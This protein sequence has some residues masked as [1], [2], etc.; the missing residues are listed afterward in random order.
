M[1]KKESLFVYGT[2]A[3]SRLQNEL[4]GR[5][6]LGVADKLDGYALDSV[7]IR[8]TTYPAL[9]PNPTANVDGLVLLVTPHE[10]EILD[11]YETAAY[12]RVQVTLKSMNPAWVY[13]KAQTA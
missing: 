2:L 3:D 4:L 7:V 1:E 6:V 13:I 12:Q 5:S 8:E 11:R 9:V 10:L